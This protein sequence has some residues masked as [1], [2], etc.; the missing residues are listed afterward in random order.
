MLQGGTAAAAVAVSGVPF[1]VHA[2]GNSIAGKEVIDWLKANAI[3]LATAEPDGGFQDIEPLRAIIGNARVISLGEA[4]HG[5][6]EFFQLKHRL[7][8]YCVAELGVTMIGFEAEYGATLAVNDYVLTGKGNAAD[9]VSGMRFWTWRTEEVVAL[10]EW[11][12][13]WN[14]AHERKVKFYGF[15]MQSSAAAAV[16]MLTYLAR[17]APDLG[18]ASE[19]ILAP[20]VSEV[21]LGDFSNLPT[22]MQEG[23]FTQIKSVIEAFTTERTHWV[24]HS[25]EIEW[26]LARQS[27]VLLDQYARSQL[28]KDGHEIFA[29]RDRSMASNVRTLLDTEGPG[30]KAVLWA[31]N[32]HVQRS[33]YFEYANMG[34][35]LNAE[36][37]KDVAIVGFAFNQGDF[38]A[39]TYGKGTLEKQVVGPAPSGFLDAALAETGIPLFAL[40]LTHVPAH[41]PVAQ[42]MASKPLQRTIGALFTAEEEKEYALAADPR[43]NFDVLVFVERTTM[44]RGYPWRSGA[45]IVNASNGGNEEP[46]NLALAGSGAIPDAWRL[47][48]FAIFP[49]AATAGTESPNGGR[50]VKIARPDAPLPWGDGM[51]TQNFPAAPWRGRQLT[52]SAAMRAEAP[53][54]GTGATLLIGI[55][56]KQEKGSDRQTAKSILALQSDGPVRSSGWTRRSVTIDVP[57]DADRI[58]ICLVVTGN[59]AGWFGDLEL[60]PTGA[61]RS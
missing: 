24:R 31:H 59:A 17:V 42:W 45:A 51:L 58:Q 6:R 5:T 40:D 32:G 15:D 57:A 10:V 7:I 18:G 46:T 29:F 33:R 37:G 53:H 1:A 25:S 12:R 60:E 39:I 44:A 50:A 2:L 48:D 47:S 34:S 43:D 54:I 3:P 27:A 30:A 28:L 56:P 21:T 36:F 4:T 35:F 13:A 8:S 61:A 26:S 52:F 38:Q 41:E 9:V 23:M 19:R 55:W 20:L 11:V 16:H 49:Y 22:S 14:L